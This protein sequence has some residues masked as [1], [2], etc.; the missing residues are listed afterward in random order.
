MCY[1]TE[2]GHSASKAVGIHTG[3]PKNREV[4]NSAV[5]GWEAWLTTRYTPSSTCYH[6]KF[7]SSVRKGVSINRKE[8]QNW[9]MLGCM[10][11]D[12][13]IHSS[14]TCYPAKFGCSRSNSTSVIKE[15]CLKNDSSHHAF[16]GYSRSWEPKWIDPPPMSSY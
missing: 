14:S 13:E 1:H 11:D 7:G 12:P 8:R 9:G 16:Q 10:A 4:L 2:F 5:L 6:V 15:I 3:E